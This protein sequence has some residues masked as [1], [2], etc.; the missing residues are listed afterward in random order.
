MNWYRAEILAGIVLTGMIFALAGPVFLAW[1]SITHFILPF[2]APYLQP[3]LAETF[4]LL[5]LLIPLLYL[6]IWSTN[7]LC[8]RLGI[9]VRYEAADQKQSTSS[10]QYLLSHALIAIATG[11]AALMFYVVMWPLAIMAVFLMPFIGEPRA[12]E[13]ASDSVIII[14]IVVWLVACRCLLHLFKLDVARPNDLPSPP[15]TP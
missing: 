13:A 15:P 11:F 10:G 9:P 2:L 3:D 6:P 5:T 14:L 12:T 1:P 4:L 7:R 8:R